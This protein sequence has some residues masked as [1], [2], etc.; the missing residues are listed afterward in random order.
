MELSVALRY[1]EDERENTTLTPTAFLPTPDASTGEVRKDT[2][3]EVQPRVSLR[4]QPSDALTLYGSWGRGFRSGGFNQTG[5]G[6]DP[7]AQSL[8]V[9]DQ[10]DAEVA[11]TLEFGL[12]SLFADNRVSFNFSV[13][14]TQAEG[15]YFFLFL[16]TSSTQNLGSLGAV[17]YQ[18]FELDLT[19]R[20]TDNL[21]ATF[22]YGK[23]D[24]EIKADSPFKDPSSPSAVGNQ[25][26]LVTE[27]TI[28]LGLQYHRPISGGNEFV[29]GAEYQRLGETWWDPANSTVRSPVNLLGLRLGVQSDDWS[30]MLWGKNINDVE[31]N[32]E[33]SPGGFVFKGKPARYGIDFTKRF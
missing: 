8:G 14:D 3:D 28:N 24:S 10:F 6:A 27:D 9:V 16:A 17:D 29:A 31:Y 15:S 26:P 5:V 19:A 25:A 18:G 11:D 32:T 30:V 23:T 13:F 4:F 21:D 22:A 12:K 2:W 20:L 33:W 7:L 1:D